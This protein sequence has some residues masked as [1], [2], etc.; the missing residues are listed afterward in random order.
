MIWYDMIYLWYMIWY[1]IFMVWDDY[2]VLL[3]YLWYGMILFMIK[4]GMIWY[5]YGIIGDDFD[6]IQV[7]KKEMKIC[8]K[9]FILS[10]KEYEYIYLSKYHVE[11]QNIGKHLILYDISYP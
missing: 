3:I 10:N 9:I 6:A 1:D 4:Y 5:I 11:L 2:D 8:E 7:A